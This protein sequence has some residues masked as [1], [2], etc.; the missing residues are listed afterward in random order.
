MQ[1]K[2]EAIEG[3]ANYPQLDLY[4]RQLFLVLALDGEGEALVLIQALTAGE[5]GT[6]G[7]GWRGTTVDQV[8]NAFWTCETGFPRALETAGHSSLK[9]ESLFLSLIAF[10]QKVN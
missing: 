9:L 8:Y 3:R 6:S 2:L 7:I 5:H 1:E 10:R 4:N